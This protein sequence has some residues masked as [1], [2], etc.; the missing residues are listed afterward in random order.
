MKEG[1]NSYVNALLPVQITAFIAVMT[2]NMWMQ[3]MAAMKFLKAQR[4]P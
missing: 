2:G 1:A 3:I 4:N